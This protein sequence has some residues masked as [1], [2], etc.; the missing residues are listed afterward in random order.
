MK[1]E[2]ESKDPAFRR[3]NLFDHRKQINANELISLDY[4]FFVPRM[5]ELVSELFT[6]IKSICPDPLH[7]L[8]FWHNKNADLNSKK[9]D[10]AEEARDSYDRQDNYNV[11]GLSFYLFMASKTAICSVTGT[12][13]V[14]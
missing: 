6:G 7:L 13:E 9:W 11:I 2:E 14:L 12:E 3:R 5:E 8:W 1:S 10:E 4:A